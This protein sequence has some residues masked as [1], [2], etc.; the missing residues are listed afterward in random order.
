MTKTY[1]VPVVSGS[2]F[3]N[4]DIE[5]MIYGLPINMIGINITN[6]TNTTGLVTDD[7]DSSGNYN[8][9]YMLPTLG[10]LNEPLITSQ[11][12]TVKKA[13]FYKIK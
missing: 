1:T 10:L 13:V 7:I 4:K 3:S 12:S 8:K 6:N 11:T 2:T 9:N 5:S